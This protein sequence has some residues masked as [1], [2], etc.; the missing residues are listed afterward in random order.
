MMIKI[1]TTI[2]INQGYRLSIKNAIT[3]FL[4]HTFSKS[5]INIVVRALINLK[6]FF[7]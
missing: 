6:L 2:T 1:I 3:T 7:S 4:N 5:F